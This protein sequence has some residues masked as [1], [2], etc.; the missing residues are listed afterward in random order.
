MKS[1]RTK[2]FL[3]TAVIVIIP[4][5]ITGYLSENIS[6]SILK[7]RINSSNQAS[8]N[9]LNNYIDAMKQN[10]ETSLNDLSKSSV[11]QTFKDG[12]DEQSLVNKLKDVKENN[13]N[14]LNVYFTL[15]DG[16]TYIYPNR[17]I[18]NVNYSEQQSYL[19]AAKIKGGIFWSNSHT[20]AITGE[21]EI[22]LTKAILDNNDNVIGVVGIDLS[23][24]K[25]SDNL[26]KIKIGQN[27]Y[28]MLIDKDGTIIAHPDKKMLYTMIT[29]YD[30]GKKLLSMQ[31]VLSSKN[32]TIE[33]TFNNKKW[34]AT[35]KLLSDFGWTAAVTTSIDELNNDISRIRN[36]IFIAIIISLVVGLLLS[37]L[38]IT[39]ITK[40][41]KKLKTTLE[42]ASSGDLTTSINL[43]SKDEIGA[44]S[45]SF[46]T[47][48]Q[49]LRTLITN[50]NNVS[51]S[52]TNAS[53]SLAA[54]SEQASQAMQDVSKAIQQ[55]AEGASSQAENAQNSANS[56]VELGKLIDTSMDDAKNIND[57]LIN[58][59]EVSKESLNIV[60]D[61]LDKTQMNINS[62]E[63]VKESTERLFEKSNKIGNIV[64]VITQIA[65]QTNLLSLN[66]AIEAA[67]AGDAGRGFSVVADEVR[68]LAEQSS[69]AAKD[70]SMLINEIQNDIK[71]TVDLV[72]N[73]N[74]V[75]NEQSE[76]VN[77]TKEVFNGII[78]AIKFITERINA[79]NESLQNIEKNKN[80]IIEAIQDIAAISEETAASTEE[81]SASSEEQTAIIEEL[82]E[83]AKQLKGTANILRDNVN[84]FK[85][86]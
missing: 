13:Q 68:K 3:F 26:S 81:V 86:D 15:S 16:K 32:N 66:A 11:V 53:D 45:K 24:S 70:I 60:N 19:N 43:K 37:L 20:D 63:K 1:I 6:Q 2:I 76:T 35:G 54:S 62:N 73:S 31:N 39:N 46:N 83:T 42:L 25:I 77:N 38:F 65:D 29:K 17:D 52:M 61:L 82:S 41:I 5:L 9:V 74:K 79:L 58:V 55:V 30:F 23:I 80:T 34:F 57:E 21:P 71:S 28:L 40:G 4:L 47:M 18:S 50:I 56:T 12:S 10:G 33:Y 48:L 75:V 64:K 27:G 44:L 84:K 51:E 69:N 14:I 22:T 8:L 78:E 36:S 85:I 59:N 7:S 72:E 67:R 49:H